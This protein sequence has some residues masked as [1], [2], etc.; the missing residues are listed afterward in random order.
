MSD[1]IVYKKFPFTERQGKLLCP[2]KPSTNSSRESNTSNPKP[3][4][5]ISVIWTFVLSSH[6]YRTAH[7]LK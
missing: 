7:S 3:P 1:N 2:Q 6:Y 5:L 4:N